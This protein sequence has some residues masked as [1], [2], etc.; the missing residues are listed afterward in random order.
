MNI[1]AQTTVIYNCSV[2]HTNLTQWTVSRI[3]PLTEEI[4]TI[5]NL[6]NNPTQNQ[7]SIFF[8]N[9]TFKYG[10]YKFFF[11][12]TL[13]T[14]DET[15]SPFVATVTHYIK[16]VPTGFIVSGFPVGF[17]E[18]PQT[19]YTIGPFDSISL[20]P[21][22]YSYDAD[23]LVNQKTL[24]FKFYCMIADFSGITN[25]TNTTSDLYLM[26]PNGQLT[27]EQLAAE[28]TCFKSIGINFFKIIILLLF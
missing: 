21:A 24:F 3:D 20:V 18:M 13:I 9:G 19:S 27:D 6:T 1:T 25:T 11:N 23:A 14:T 2:V 5:Y 17:F 22:F 4:L 12:F 10:L 28:D 8:A 7:T 16:V 26:N 15:V